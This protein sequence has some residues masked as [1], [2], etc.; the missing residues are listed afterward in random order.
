MP[1]VL[2]VLLPVFGLLLFGWGATFLPAFDRQA[3][4]GLAV[5]VFWFALPV[6]LFRTT[7]GTDAAAT[8]EWRF[9]AAYYGG[10]FLVFAG[11]LVIARRGQGRTTAESAILAFGATYSNMVMLGI[12]LII[13]AFGQAGS[14]AIFLLVAFHSILVF[15]TV[16]VLIELGRG[17]GARLRDLPWNTAKGLITNPILMSLA[18]GLLAGHLGLTLPEAVDRVAEQLGRAAV[19]CAL[20]ALGASLRHYRIVGGLRVAALP[21]VGK[22]LVMPALIYLLAFHVFRLG[23][24]WAAVA[25][26]VAALPTGVNPYLFAERYDT[27]VGPIATSILVTTLISVATVSALLILLH[28]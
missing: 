13:T 4:R 25:V 5:F 9:L 23:A 19:P 24:P 17:D 14:V 28:G 3:Q 22:A 20:F 8:L 11:A 1:I 10:L 27:L 15:P 26:V 16:T 6:A 18:L 12:P 2:D 21:I 7:L